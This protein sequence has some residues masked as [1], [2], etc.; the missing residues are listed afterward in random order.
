MITFNVNGMIDQNDTEDSTIINR[1]LDLQICNQL[2]ITQITEDNV[3]TL[4][5]TC[6]YPYLIYDEIFLSRCYP[7]HFGRNGWQQE[8]LHLLAW[9]KTLRN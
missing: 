3:Q 9:S 7:I 6:V 4:V 8:Q 2:V 1:I 5:D